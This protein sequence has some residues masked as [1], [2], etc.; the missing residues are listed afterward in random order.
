M[1]NSLLVFGLELPCDKVFT[2]RKSHF[3][4]VSG[5]LE[6][7][8]HPIVWKFLPRQGVSVYMSRTLPCIMVFLF[9]TG[10]YVAW[11]GELTP[12]LIFTHFGGS[13]NVAPLGTPWFPPVQQGVCG[14]RLWY[15]V[16]LRSRSDLDPWLL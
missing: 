10:W 9:G 11:Q 3:G 8:K 13:Y 5:F 2:L 16:V 4:R 7:K 14:F 1:T 6:V 15:L 12:S